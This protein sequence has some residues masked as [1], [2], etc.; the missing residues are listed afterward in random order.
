MQFEESL[1]LFCQINT[2]NV[3]LVELS[4]FSSLSS[5]RSESINRHVSTSLK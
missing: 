4:V 3:V 1:F 2:S 5:W